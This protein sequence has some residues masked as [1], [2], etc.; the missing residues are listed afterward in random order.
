[1]FIIHWSP[2]HDKV[3]KDFEQYLNLL[4]RSKDTIRAY[5]YCTKSFLEHTE[6]DVEELSARDVFEYLVYLKEQL[7]QANST[8]NQKRAALRVFFRD[9]L[10]KPL[11]NT[12]LKYSKRPQHIPEILTPSEVEQ[13]LKAT[14]N[15]KGR[16]ILM[17]IYSAGLRVSEAVH[18]KP[19]DIDSKSMKIHIRQAKGQKD[20]QTML[21]EK[22]LEKLRLYWKATRPQTWL[23]PGF[24][25]TKPISIRCVQK[26]FKA[27]LMKAGIHRPLTLHSLRHSFATHLLEA[28]VSLPYI[29]QLLGHSSIKT[30]LIY[31]KVAPESAKIKSPLD[32]LSL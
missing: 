17:T 8:L 18:I 24:D 14:D 10:E 29:Q 30:T 11:P 27:S 25:P 4:G 1:M 6:K 13:V 15:L 22:L 32:S 26:T 5:K 28:G 2:A 3:L 16:T 12:L 9:I 20:R 31:L 7:G 19:S 23:F 21:S